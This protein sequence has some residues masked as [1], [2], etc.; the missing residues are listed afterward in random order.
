MKSR[1]FSERFEK[2]QWTLVYFDAL[3]EAFT[4][5]KAQTPL[6]SLFGISRRADR[7]Q[8]E[9]KGPEN[10]VLFELPDSGGATL[11]PGVVM[12]DDE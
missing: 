5:S 11:C 3:R 2:D 12:K 7:R 10:Q 8:P 1:L 4:K 6:E 9:E